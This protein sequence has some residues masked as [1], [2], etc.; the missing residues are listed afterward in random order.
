MTERDESLRPL[1][2]ALVASV[3]LWQV[4]YGPYLLYPFKLLGTWL[5]EGSHALAMLMSGAG[6]SG[7]EVFADGS[8]LA[9]A[10]SLAG[11]IAG[12]FIAAAG[13][14]GAPVG[15][16]ILVLGARDPRGAR[17]ALV[18][19]GLVL[20]VT[21][22]ASITNRFGQVAIG[23]TGAVII[24]V[25][26]VPRPRL[27]A[28]LAHLLAAQACVGALVD[29]RVLFRPNLIVDGQVVR[30]SDAH[31][32]AV[33]TFGTDASWAVWTWAAIWLA[34]S[35]ALLFLVLRRLR[36]ASA[37]PPSAPGPRPAD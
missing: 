20:A 25:A 29:I 32:M 19:L 36:R 2:L 3:V 17:R 1:A 24:A 12:G 6:F 4:P 21:A 27:H 16:V 30:D 5:H 34:W 13:Y 33:A 7:M 28:G 14:M 31:A 26:A 11:P 18:G 15:G 8:G 37:A 10:Q 22:L 23:A 9:H 35:L